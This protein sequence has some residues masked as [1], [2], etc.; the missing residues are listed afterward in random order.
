MTVTDDAPAPLLVRLTADRIAEA[1]IPV[2][3]DKYGILLIS[4]ESSTE[5]GTGRWTLALDD[6]AHVHLRFSPPTAGTSD[7]H[8]IADIAAALLTGT[9]GTGEPAPGAPPVNVIGIKGVA[10]LDLRARGFR[11]ELNTYVFDDTLELASDVSATVPGTGSREPDI[12]GIAYIADDGSISYERSF[13]QP[14][15][16]AAARTIATTVTAAIHTAHPGHD[17]G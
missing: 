4:P 15:P 7:P 5:S 8:R 2:S 12:V 13:W 6:D 1:G 9:P 14:D 17:V 16:S 3:S 10:G 11:V